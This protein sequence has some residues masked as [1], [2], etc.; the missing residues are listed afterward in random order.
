[1]EIAM[2]A[3]RP[4]LPKL[5]NLLVGEFTLENRVR[6]RIESLLME[7]TLM[8]AALRKVAKVPHEQLDEGVKIWAGNIKELS[9]HMEDI[10]DGYMLQVGDGGEPTNPKNKVKK[11]AKKTRKLFKKRKNLHRISHA[12]EEAVGQAKQLAELRQR[13]EQDI[14]YIGASVNADATGVSVDPRVMALYTDVTELVGIAEA[15]DELVTM[16]LVGDGW[17]KHP[18]KTVSIVGF[19]GLGKTTLAKAAYEKIKVQFD[20]DAFVSISR[21]PDMKKVFKDILYELDKNKYASISNATLDQRQLIDV[22]IDFLTNKRYLIVIDDI[23]DEKAWQLMKCA[24]S[25]NSIGSR[26]ITTTRIVS[27]SE[28][29]CSSRDD[30]YRMK[31]L[32]GDAS[33][34]LFQK[35]VFSNEEWC[36]PE[37]V[38]V[39]KGILHKCGGIPLAIISIA[40]LLAS[41]R[42]IKTKDQWYALLNSIGRGLTEDHSVEEMKKILLFS[43]YD[44][45]S[46]LKPCLLYLSIFPE[47][48]IIMRGKLVWKWISEGFVYSEIQETSLYELGD[49]YFSELVNR[50]MIQ[51]I[52]ID[53]EE[54]VKACRVHDMVLDLICS[55]ASEENFVTILDGTERKLTNLQSKARRLSIQNSKVNMATISMTKV[56]SLTV[57]TNDIV[58][59]LH[60][61]STF[62]VLRLLDL[63]HS[64]ISDTAYVGNLLHLRYLGLKYNGLEEL[65]MEIGKLPLLQTLHISGNS[66]KELP[67]SIVRLRNLMCLC[68]GGGMK[69]P[70]GIGN[71]TSLEV[72]VGPVV[73]CT[74]NHHLVKELGHLTRLRVLQ[75]LWENLDE[76]MCKAMVESLNNLRKLEVLD[77]YI[78]GGHVDLVRE[79]WV[80][81]PQ[82]RKLSFNT[83]YCQF[84]TLPGWIN[85]CSLHILSYLKI[86]LDEVRSEDIQIIGMLPAL[87]YLV[88]WVDDSVLEKDMVEIFVV[89]P[90]SFPCVTEC[91]FNYIPAVPSIFP[92]GAA[93]RLKHLEF[94]FPA[95][96]ISRGDIDLDMRHLPSLENVD[97]V[98]SKYGATD[99]EVKEANA[100]LRGAA[101]DHPNHPCISIY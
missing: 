43:Y 29:C 68:V 39:S 30:I 1:M 9:Y 2:V 25:K 72:L 50:S 45:P 15:Q 26:L 87:R 46:Y 70:F 69:L 77:I 38:Q 44:L 84:L 16:L 59:Q 88:L 60:K 48:Q 81:P 99:V 74:F 32:T 22:I 101:A 55:L 23:W 31:P 75:F 5:G 35:R 61:V 7:L 66:K 53:D 42:Q 89:T 41:N 63:E 54:K 71:L 33:R 47:D 73:A 57:F 83:P 37:F 76:S 4:L 34:R 21:N 62:Q 52:G 97:V 10:I 14:R 11:L 3:I 98:L 27:V 18:L 86:S 49:S 100:A 64:P 94:T 82:L 79:G 28:A 20:C 80:P 40:S 58:Q 13:Y 65:P 51:P 85:P 24:F 36:P 17:S 93:P 96:W 92:Q 91:H 56:R 12:L 78:K 8:H 90:D 67:S 6:K 95:M 19:G